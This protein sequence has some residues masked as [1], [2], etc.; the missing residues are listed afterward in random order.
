M[1]EALTTKENWQTNTMAE[2]LCQNYLCINSYTYTKADIIN[3]A[4]TCEKMLSEVIVHFNFSTK[5]PK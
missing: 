3:F 2:I 1:K 4:T 5:C